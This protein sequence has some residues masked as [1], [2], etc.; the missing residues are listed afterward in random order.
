MLRSAFAIALCTLVATPAF[1]QRAAKQNGKRGQQVSAEIAPAKSAATAEQ[2]I[3]AALQEETNLEFVETPLKEALTYIADKHKFDLQYDTVALRDAAVDPTAIPVSI[4]VHGI[5]L[6]SALNLILSQNNLTTIMQD[7]VLQITTKDK[8]NS[9]LVMHVYDVHDL[10]EPENVEQ[11]IGILSSVP[12][13]QD[14]VGKIRWLRLS[15]K[16]T[17][18]VCK[19]ESVHDGIKEILA[20]LRA[21]ATKPAQ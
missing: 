18:F 11:L 7:E 2:R 6:A 1:A 21:V 8:A 17:L 3:R 16:Y 19:P 12:G 20:D 4:N 13:D 5:K 10:A 15:G 14:A 9:T